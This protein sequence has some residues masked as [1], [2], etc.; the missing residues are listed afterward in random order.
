MRDGQFGSTR[1]GMDTRRD[2]QARIRKRIQDRLQD[3]RMTQRELAKATGHD[4]AWI[5]GILAGRHGLH[6]KD[7]DAVAEKLRVSPSELVRADDAELRELTPTETKLLKHFQAWPDHI[8]GRWLEVLDFFSATSPDRETAVLMTLL[9][10][11]PRSLRAPV[12][13]WLERLLQ[14]GIPLE[15]L[16]A[17]DAPETTGPTSGTGTT[18]RVRRD[19][20]LRGSHGR[21]RK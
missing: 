13:Q 17:A 15:A 21:V 14:A 11:T 6:W 16:P 12:M 3:L 19:G 8:K 5:S 7:F 20:S 2:V 18:H 10:D 1:S 4:D 9:R